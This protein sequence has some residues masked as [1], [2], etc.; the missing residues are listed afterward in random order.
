M[1]HSDTGTTLTQLRFVK[2][3]RLDKMFPEKRNKPAEKVFMSSCPLWFDGT[4]FE[5]IIRTFL[6]WKLES[7]EKDLNSY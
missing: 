5:N 7:D 4:M 3:A 1:K 2:A 6:D